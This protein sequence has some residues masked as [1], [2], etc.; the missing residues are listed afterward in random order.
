M[1]LLKPLQI[2][3]YHFKNRVV[4]PPMC[5]Y[6][7]F[8][9][10]G[11]VTDFHIS[12][13]TMRAIGQVG[14]IIVES[15]MIDK[16]GGLSDQ[17]LG[18]YN[19]SQIKGLKRLTSAVH[20]QDSLIGIQLNHAGRKSNYQ[21]NVSASAI[22]Y[23][24]WRQTP[25]ELTVDEIYKIIKQ[26]GQAAKRANKAG[27][28]LIEVHAAHGYLINQFISPVSNK[29]TDEFSKPFYFLQLI[30]D[31]INKYWPKEK[32]LSIR[33]SIDDLVDGGIEFEQFVE[34]FKSCKPDL[35]NVTTGGIIPVRKEEYIGYQMDY[36]KKLKEATNVRVIAGGLLTI[37]NAEL[38]LE[39]FDYDLVY[40]GRT[41]LRKPLALLNETNIEWPKVYVRANIDLEKEKV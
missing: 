37:G 32:L 38:E 31:E 28:D 15:T 1:K 11:R 14:L 21:P 6:S 7:V 33:I 4:M 35:V 26:F 23:S 41:L 16:N 34:F 10:D 36:A 24:D 22:Q 8:K 40:L 20:F 19:N 30:L 12:H 3:D 18:I 27:F 25:K 29:R 2:K 9:E 39:K 13:Y 5:T 17:D